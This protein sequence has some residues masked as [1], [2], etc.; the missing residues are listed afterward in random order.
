MK[1]GKNMPSDF[2]KQRLCVDRKIENLL[3]I[4]KPIGQSTHYV[5]QVGIS[6]LL[7][8]V[9]AALPSLCQPAKN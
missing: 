6:N 7:V 8:T 2:K 3:N 1:I 9:F 4:I 5:Q